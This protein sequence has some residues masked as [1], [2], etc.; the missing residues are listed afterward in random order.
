MKTKTLCPPSSSR[1]IIFHE[2]LVAARKTWLVDALRDALKLVDQNKLK[3]E[4]SL[5]VPED[6]QKLLASSAIRDEF[7]F[8][9]PVVLKAKPSLVGYYRL[10]LG[11]PQKSFL[12]KRYWARTV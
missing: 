3:K 1:Q 4:L 5:Y 11:A 10:L 2:L 12:C 8:P 7:V 6:V 9:T